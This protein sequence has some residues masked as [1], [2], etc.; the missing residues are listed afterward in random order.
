LE[1]GGGRPNEEE[2]GH[3]RLDVEE[4]RRQHLGEEEVRRR[5]LYLNLGRPRPFYRRRGSSGAV[6]NVE[7]ARPISNRPRNEPKHT[8][9]TEVRSLQELGT[10]IE[11]S[12]NSVPLECTENGGGG[13]DLFYVTFGFRRGHDL[14]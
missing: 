13:G 5:R 8:S 2:A 9:K 14:P 10:G 4:T 11:F 7:A 12:N 3:R 1:A 6:E